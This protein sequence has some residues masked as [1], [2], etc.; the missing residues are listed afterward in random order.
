MNTYTRH[1]CNGCI[2]LEYVHARADD[3]TAHC[4]D[5][6]KGVLGARRTVYHSKLDIELDGRPIIS[7]GWCRGKQT[8]GKEHGR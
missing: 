4:L 3:H 5:P 1:N 7:P 6:D 8:G 2:Y